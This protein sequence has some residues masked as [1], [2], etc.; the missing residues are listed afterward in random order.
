MRTMTARDL[1]NHTGKAMKTVSRGEKVVVTLR[2]RPFAL[3]SPVTSE[4]LGEV[5]LRP[6]EEAWKEIEGTLKK[7]RP[8]FRNVKEAMDWTRKR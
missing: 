6:P 5:A 3:I 1:K 4:S 2:G 8:R 7:T